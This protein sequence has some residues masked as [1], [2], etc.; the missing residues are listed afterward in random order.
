MKHYLCLEENQISYVGGKLT[1]K[2][3]RIK[4]A[5]RADLPAEEMEE[6]LRHFV[7]ANHIKGKKVTLSLDSGIIFN[8]YHLPAVKEGELRGMVR[9]ELAYSTRNPDDYT[10]SVLP[11]KKLEDGG[12]MVLVHAVREEELA[13]KLGT[14]RHAGI[15][16]KS[17][18][19]HADC[20]G[21]LASRQYPGNKIL[22]LTEID[23]DQIRMFLIEDVCCVLSRS[24]RLN[25]TRFLDGDSL[26][27]LCEE[28]VDQ[29]SKVVQFHTGR[30]KKDP[31]EKIVL[32]SDVIP[33]LE[34]AAGW[35]GESMRMECEPV[36]WK[37]TYSRKVKE[38]TVV[39]CFKGMA[40]MVFRKKHEPVNVNFLR[41]RII[42][43]RKE[44]KEG[45]LSWTVQSALLFAVSI[46][47]AGGVWYV[48][49]QKNVECVARTAQLTAYVDE[50]ERQAR[51]SEIMRQQE[52]LTRVQAYNM[53]LDDV[54][55]AVRQKNLLNY[56]AYVG[57]SAP[58]PEN[59]SVVGMTYQEGVLSFKLRSEDHGYIPDYVNA[60]KESGVFK[61][62]WHPMWGKEDDVNG[63]TGFVADIYGTLEENAEVESRLEEITDE[64]E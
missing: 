50:E 18:R 49:S 37:F 43:I 11:Y 35:I 7:K 1:G 42:K 8:E 27:L 52:E 22:L 10:I 45:F 48:M 36:N 12:Y 2:G 41:D 40:A 38:E 3:F 20:M 58:V 25:V 34:T 6:A 33:Q 16:C 64:A 46:C 24:Q 57:L 13:E 29:I 44:R 21:S 32:V 56:R 4:K 14:L 61:R 47:A 9:S 26:N 31:I 28:A 19:V 59:V 62:I 51:Y 53:K 60:V 17:V 5:A 23:R 30:N 63:G 55:T 39:S 15:R 54:E